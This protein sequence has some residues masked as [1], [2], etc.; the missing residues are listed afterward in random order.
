MLLWK[1][2]TGI[3]HGTTGRAFHTYFVNS[4]GSFF[5]HPRL[6]FSSPGTLPPKPSDEGEQVIAFS[7][8]SSRHLID[9]VLMITL[10]ARSVIEVERCKF[11]SA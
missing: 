11:A 8:H 5:R 6:Y 10:L 4:D 3:E 1:R 9:G 7:L 2:Q